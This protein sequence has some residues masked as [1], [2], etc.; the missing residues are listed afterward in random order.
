MTHAGYCIMSRRDVI[1]RSTVTI[2][3]ND[4]FGT[5]YPPYLSIKPC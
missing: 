1:W 4:I 3:S 5:F 2:Y